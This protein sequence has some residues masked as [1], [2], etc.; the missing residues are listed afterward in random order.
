MPAYI[1][2]HYTLCSFVESKLCIGYSGSGVQYVQ[3]TAHSKLDSQLSSQV[4]SL[5]RSLIQRYEAQF[6][7][8]LQCVIQ[9]VLECGSNGFAVWMKWFCNTVL[10][11]KN[12]KFKV[13]SSKLRRF[14]LIRLGE[15]PRVKR[16]GTAQKR[17]KHCYSE[18][19]LSG[20]NHYRPPCMSYCESTLTSQ[21][22]YRALA[23]GL[24]R[25]ISANYA[26]YI[27]A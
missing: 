7:D 16:P 4:W 10:S 26:A 18:L 19:N 20:C 2:I 27:W 21:V 13:Q 6:A 8:L 5:I 24:W 22:Q 23:I 9:M 3:F 17:G 25:I 11:N 14:R 15:V 1:F 12:T